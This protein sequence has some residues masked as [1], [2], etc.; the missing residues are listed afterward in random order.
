VYKGCP[1]KGDTL[2]KYSFSAFSAF[3]AQILALDM[4]TLFIVRLVAKPELNS[5]SVKFAVVSS[6]MFMILIVFWWW[7]LGGFEP[8]G[9]PDR[10]G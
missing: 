3:S 9:N 2:F 1:S 5:S 7:V 6:L 4:A 8:A 10:L